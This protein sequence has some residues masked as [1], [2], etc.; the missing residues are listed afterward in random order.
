MQ[1]IKLVLQA[2]VD[3][4]SDTKLDPS[5][6]SLVDSIDSTKTF[7]AVTDPSTGSLRVGHVTSVGQ[8]TVVSSSFPQFYKNEKC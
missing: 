7:R 3:N 4:A 6:K 2:F 1:E 5:V 8:V